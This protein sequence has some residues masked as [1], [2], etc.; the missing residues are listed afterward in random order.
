[1]I[2]GQRSLSASNWGINNRL[3]MLVTFYTTRRRVPYKYSYICSNC[4]VIIWN[5]KHEYKRTGQQISQRHCSIG[6]TKTFKSCIFVL[7]LTV[8]EILIFEIFDLE[9]VGHGR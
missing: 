5:F 7:A 9:K 8:N 1:M 2:L 6:N 3:E 4:L